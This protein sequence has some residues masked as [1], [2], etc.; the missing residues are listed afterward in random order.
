M[1]VCFIYI[2]PTD[3]IFRRFGSFNEIKYSLTDTT[4]AEVQK[5]FGERNLPK[6]HLIETTCILSDDMVFL[7]YRFGPILV[8]FDHQRP[9]MLKLIGAVPIIKNIPYLV[10]TKPYQPATNKRQPLYNP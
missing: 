4:S 9:Q 1:T 2:K 3:L 7:G 8:D 6:K 5:S 10:M